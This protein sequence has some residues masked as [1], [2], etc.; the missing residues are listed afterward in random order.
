M[1]AT[2]KTTHPA[3]TAAQAIYDAAGDLAPHEQAFLHAV[4]KIRGDCNRTKTTAVYMFG[5]GSRAAL[6][7]HNLSDRQEGH[8]LDRALAAYTEAMEE[9]A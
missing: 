1:T 8:D 3:V 6:A 5:L 2:T 9:V 7:S 4:H